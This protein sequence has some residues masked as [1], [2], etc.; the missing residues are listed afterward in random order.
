LTSPGFMILRAGCWH[1]RGLLQGPSGQ[2]LSFL[3]VHE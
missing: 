3:V 2:N 1:W